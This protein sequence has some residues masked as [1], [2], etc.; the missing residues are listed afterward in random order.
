MA[1]WGRRDA[2]KQAYILKASPAPAQEASPS[3]DLGGVNWTSRLWFSD[4]VTCQNCS[5]KCGSLGPVSRGFN[6]LCSEQ[7]VIVY[8]SDRFPGASYVSDPGHYTSEFTGLR[9]GPCPS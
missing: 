8:T 1:L 2:R 3:S 9:Q 6:L 4:F 7:S 5:S